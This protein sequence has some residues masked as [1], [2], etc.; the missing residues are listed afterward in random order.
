MLVANGSFA[1]SA[2]SNSASGALEDDVEVH[3]ED[4]GEGVI[5]HTQIDV[6]LD[7]E[8]EAT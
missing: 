6:F 5:L 2:E 3:T 7:A 1:S 4:T 8:S